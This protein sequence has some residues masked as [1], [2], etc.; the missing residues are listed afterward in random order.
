[1]RI[2]FLGTGNAFSESG[3]RPSAHLIS[4]GSTNIL[5]DCGPSILPALY[6]NKIY[7]NEI[8]SIYISHLH[9]DHYF[10]LLFLVL[11]NYHVSRRGNPINVYCPK[12]TEEKILSLAREMYNEREVSSLKECYV[13]IEIGRDDKILIDEG[14][15]RTIPAIHDGEG[16]MAIFNLPGAVIGYSGDTEFNPTGLDLMIDHCDII[17]HE[18]T[19]AD[20]HIKGHTNLFEILDYP[21]PSSTHL[22]LTHH[23]RSTVEV[24]E[25]SYLPPNKHLARDNLAIDVPNLLHTEEFEFE[26]N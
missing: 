15:L 8:D 13:F 2:I 18:A 24:L 12:G 17:I 26:L 7:P 14:S 19:S 4:T 23:D 10:G 11:D 5:L 16:R 21:I 9:P 20:L 1:M 25:R 22:F 3:D 6:Q